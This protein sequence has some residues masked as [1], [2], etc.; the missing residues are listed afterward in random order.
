MGNNKNELR[1]WETL[2]GGGGGL[3]GGRLMPSCV[4]NDRKMK[5]Q[6]LEKVGEKSHTN[7]FKGGYELPHLESVLV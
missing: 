6:C 2:R 7:L 1:Q 5:H 3:V 4:M